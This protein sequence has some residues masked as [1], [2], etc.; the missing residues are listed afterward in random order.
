MPPF[1]PGGDERV[2]WNVTGVLLIAL[3]WG[4]AVVLNVVLHLAAPTGGLAVGPV[5]I[6]S[7]LGPLAWIT[8]G[9]GVFTGAVGVGLLL[10]AREAP[11]KPVVLPGY[12]Y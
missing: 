3:G 4:L 6:F 7:T 8:L 1:D 11:R 10:V 2:G 12:P 5:R 9:L